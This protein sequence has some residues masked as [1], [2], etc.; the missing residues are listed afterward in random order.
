MQNLAEPVDPVINDI[1]DIL[2]QTAECDKKGRRAAE[3]LAYPADQAVAPY[4]GADL[5]TGDMFCQV[6]CRDL[7]RGG[8]SFTWPRPPEFERVVIKVAMPDRPMYFMAR[9]VNYRSLNDAGNRYLVGCEFLDRV[10]IPG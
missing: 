6:K 5:P 3:R 7:S 8:M 9:V 2:S 1:L 4:D 10:H